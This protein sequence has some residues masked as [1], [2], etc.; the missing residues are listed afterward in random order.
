MLRRMLPAIACVVLLA[1]CG[2]GGG[3]AVAGKPKSTASPTAAPIGRIAAVLPFGDAYVGDVISGLGSIWIDDGAVTASNAWQLIRIDPKHNTVTGAPIAV[4]QGR[5]TAFA[6]ST[7]GIAVVLSGT[8]LHLNRQGTAVAQSATQVCSQSTLAGDEAGN[9]WYFDATTQSSA[10]SGCDELARYDAA[11]GTRIA[12]WP[13]PPSNSITALAAGD[14]QAW[15]LDNR[16][17]SRAYARGGQLEPVIAVP[18]TVG[19]IGVG[20]GVGWWITPVTDGPPMLTRVNEQ[21]LRPLGSTALI[22]P[23]RLEQGGGSVTAAATGAGRVWVA[24]ADQSSAEL[25]AFDLR[26]GQQAGA[27]VPLPGV[28]AAQGE[29][30]LAFALGSVWLPDNNE[31]IR[32][33]PSPCCTDLPPPTSAAA[34]TTTVPAGAQNIHPGC[35][36]FCLNAGPQGGPSGCTGPDCKP[37]PEQGCISIVTRISQASGDLVPVAVACHIATPCTGA[38]LLLPPGAGPAPDG[39]STPRSQWVAGSDFTV[40]PKSTATVELRL[41]ALG[42]QLIAQAGGYRADVWVV[43]NDHNFA[44]NYAERTLVVRR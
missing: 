2:D 24:F 35:S 18:E 31:L 15:V 14:G 21:T 37:C 11:T 16:R 40:P 12:G 30:H 8:L 32:I 7:G 1:A 28:S 17:I 26:T 33:D 34:V 13:V 43:S 29:M 23:D 22:G 27:P 10:A 39:S 3:K 6:G 38:F 25:A 44:L 36:Q 20:S 5:P 9:L 4:G 19:T 41:T 42:S